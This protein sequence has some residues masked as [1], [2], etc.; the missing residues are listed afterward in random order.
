MYADY[1]HCRHG[2]EPYAVGYSASYYF[3]NSEIG[4]GIF[5]WGQI[6]ESWKDD[7]YWVAYGIG[8]TVSTRTMRIIIGIWETMTY[9]RIITREEIRVLNFS[10][11]LDQ[12]YLCHIV[13]ENNIPY[14]VLRITLL[15]VL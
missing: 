4:S 10:L 7:T 3:G 2:E 13:M 6:F 5:S 14:Q 11:H 1:H 8:V 15:Q 9:L 12:G